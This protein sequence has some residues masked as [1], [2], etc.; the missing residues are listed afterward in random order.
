MEVNP[1]LLQA[2]Y[3]EDLFMISPPVTVIMDQPWDTITAVEKILL[4]KILTAIRQSFNSV[5]IKYQP[6]LDLAN[7]VDRPRHVIYFGKPVKG[8]PLYEA[9]EANGVTVVASENLSDLSQNEEARKKL[10]QALKKQFT[11]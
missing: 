1:V 3:A 7:W 11:V 5:A 2:T 10:W 6:S 8:V 9:V 4:E